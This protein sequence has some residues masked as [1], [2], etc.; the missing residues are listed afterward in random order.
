M[1]PH[2]AT[3]APHATPLGVRVVRFHLRVARQGLP[4]GP[5][6]AGLLEFFLGTVRANGLGKTNGGRGNHNR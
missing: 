4:S 2:A 5:W 6:M 1:T 3:M